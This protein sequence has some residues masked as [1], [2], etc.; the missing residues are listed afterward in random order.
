MHVSQNLHPDRWTVPKFDNNPIHPT[1]DIQ[2]RNANYIPSHNSLAQHAKKTHVP[3]EFLL[4]LSIPP[5]T[6]FRQEVFT[7]LEQSHRRRRSSIRNE[8]CVDR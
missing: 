1:I 3:S 8:H 2:T 7:I 6:T 5:S 4:L